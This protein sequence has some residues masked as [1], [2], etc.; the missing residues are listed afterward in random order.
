MLGQLAQSVAHLTAF[1]RF[2]GYTSVIK[3]FLR[4]FFSLPW[5]QV[6]QLSLTG[7]NHEH[8]GLVNGFGGSKPAQEQCR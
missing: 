8:L 5:I 6:R 3:Q 4:P 2:L 1:M 7:R